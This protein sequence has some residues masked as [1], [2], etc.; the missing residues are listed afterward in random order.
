MEVEKLYKVEPHNRRGNTCRKLGLLLGGNTVD[1]TIY[2][3]KTNPANLVAMIDLTN[4]DP[5]VAEGAYI[6]SMLPKFVYLSGTADVIELINYSIEEIGF[7]IDF[8]ALDISGFGYTPEQIDEYLIYH[9]FT[10]GTNNAVMDIRG[11]G[12]PT[13]ASAAARQEL[14]DNDVL[15]AYDENYIP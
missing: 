11:N 13:S 14:F 8:S 6:L 5:F 9:A 12:N 7:V 4:A 10:L 3:S 15:V 2:G 1:I